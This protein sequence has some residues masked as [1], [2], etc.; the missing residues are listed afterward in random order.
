MK[1]LYVKKMT[2][3]VILLSGIA[4]LY[5]IY[6]EVTKV[7]RLELLNNGHKQAVFDVIYNWAIDDDAYRY[8]LDE[9]NFYSYGPS[10]FVIFDTI[11]GELWVMFDDET[12]PRRESYLRSLYLRRL[13]V[14]EG[15]NEPYMREKVFESLSEKEQKVYADFRKKMPEK[16]SF[17]NGKEIGYWQ[18]RFGNIDYMKD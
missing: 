17:P 14:E 15:K 6:L 10:G 3:L 13:R 16:L 5:P 9:F 7:T 1:P 18:R 11:T 4:L 8:Y 12:D 2:V